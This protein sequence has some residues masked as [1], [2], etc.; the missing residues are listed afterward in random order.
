MAESATEGLEILVNHAELEDL[1]NEHEAPRRSVRKKHSTEK[2]YEYVR[3]LRIQAFITAK[4]SWRKRINSIHLILVT[5]QDIASLTA[6]CED[7]ERKMT[8]LSLSHEPLE[9]VMEDEAERN[10]LYEEFDVVSREKQ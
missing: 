10:R 9:T 3:N 1:D 4:R 5:R 8:Q 6:G 7:L 2:G